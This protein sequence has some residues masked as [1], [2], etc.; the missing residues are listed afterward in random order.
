MATSAVLLSSAVSLK[1]TRKRQQH[2]QGS[3]PKVFVSLRAED[4]WQLCCVGGT[5]FAA[6]LLDLDIP[7][8]WNMAVVLHTRFSL[9][10]WGGQWRSKGVRCC[11]IQEAVLLL[12]TSTANAHYCMGTCSH[13]QSCLLPPLCVQDLQGSSEISSTTSI[14]MFLSTAQPFLSDMFLVSFSLGKR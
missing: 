3:L 4:C 1:K 6:R 13:L 7:L 9:V 10:E 14:Q 8:G 5:C 2:P 12:T 11:R